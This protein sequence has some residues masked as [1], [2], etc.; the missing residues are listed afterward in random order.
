MVRLDETRSSQFIGYIGPHTL[1]Y[2]KKDEGDP[3]KK[4]M[5]GTDI[6]TARARILNAQRKTKFAPDYEKNLHAESVQDY[7][8]HNSSLSQG[9]IKTGKMF[10]GSF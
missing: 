2:A 3:Q 10:A 9:P 4:S 5:G 7:K 1:Q 8:I 6:L